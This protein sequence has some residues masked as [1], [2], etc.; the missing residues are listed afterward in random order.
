MIWRYAVQ[1]PGCGAKIV[2]RVG[3][4]LDDVQP[5][6]F[7]CDDCKAVTRGKQI[8]TYEPRPS[9]RLELDAGKLLD[10]D[11]NPNQV[12]TLHPDLPAKSESK[13]LREP[14]GSPFLMHHKIL[15][16]RFLEF[17]T[18]LKTFHYSN[19]RDWVRL[20][21]WIGY[22]LADNRQQFDQEGKCLL[23][24]KLQ[25]QWQDRERHDI[26][27]RFLDLMCAPLWLHPYYP[28]MKADWCKIFNLSIRH[29][30]TLKKFVCESIESGIIRSSQ[31]DVFHCLELFM[32]NRSGILPGLAAE[33]YPAGERA[34]IIELRLFR[35]EFPQLRDVYIATFEACHNIL[36]FVLGIIN[37]AY[38]GS[39]N[40]FGTKHPKNLDAFD[41]LSSGQKVTFLTSL[42]TW[43]KNWGLILDRHVRNAIGHHSVRHDLVSGMLVLRDGSQLPYLEFVMKTLRLIHPIL[44]S[45]NAMKTFCV[46]YILNS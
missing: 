2:L 29:S 31:K 17:N 23:K 9:A 24:G 8:I 12:I 16:D 10:D 21:R 26:I 37:I 19:Q 7:I 32:E 14:G 45:A 46:A 6:Y 40:N 5:F 42:P 1:C 3:I 38:R 15:G 4:G 39:P 11:K 30:T 18:R 13:D 27:H 41:K 25:C 44:L 36:K 43:D 22:Y 34:A 35:D 28:D 33:M 20:R